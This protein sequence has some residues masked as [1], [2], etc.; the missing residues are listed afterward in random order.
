[1]RRTFTSVCTSTGRT[2]EY[3]VPEIREW[4]WKMRCTTHNCVVWVLGKR[5]YQPVLCWGCC[6]TVNND[7]YKNMLSGCFFF[8]LWKKM[9]IFA[10]IKMLRDVTNLVKKL[11]DIIKSFPKKLS[12]CVATRNGPPDHAICEIKANNKQYANWRMKLKALLVASHQMCLW[13]CHW[14]LQWT[15]GSLEGGLA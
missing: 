9:T 2:A 7:C 4:L 13:K 14:E 5:C 10:S 6:Q 3:R 8:Q 12:L 15:H 1:M 11:L